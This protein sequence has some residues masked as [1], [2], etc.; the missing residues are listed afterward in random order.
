MLVRHDAPDAFLS[1]GDALYTMFEIVQMN[2]D[3]LD[4]FEVRYFGYFSCR[5]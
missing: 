2:F 4:I 3:N 1:M 5:L